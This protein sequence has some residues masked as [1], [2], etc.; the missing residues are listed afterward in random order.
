MSKLC[1]SWAFLCFEYV[2]VWGELK[3]L[4]FHY[5]YDWEL[6]MSMLLVTWYKR[7]CLMLT[8]FHRHQHGIE[9]VNRLKRDSI[10]G[11][12]RNICVVFIHEKSPCKLDGTKYPGLYVE[13][14]GLA[15]YR[16]LPP[17]ITCTKHVTTWNFTL[18]LPVW[19]LLIHL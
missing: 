18:L 5:L 17:T 13:G 4:F 7:R 2:N 9:A 12:W 3:L 19:T 14:G 16:I 11:W 8:Y 1:K 6:K 15:L 10:Y